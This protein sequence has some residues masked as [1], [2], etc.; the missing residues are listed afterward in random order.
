MTNSQSKEVFF[1]VKFDV[2]FLFDILYQTVLT[3]ALSNVSTSQNE[4]DTVIR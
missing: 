3:F 2:I 4:V 1:Y